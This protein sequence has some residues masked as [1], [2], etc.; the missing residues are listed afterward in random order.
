MSWDL[1]V[2][3]PEHAE[4]PSDWLESLVEEAADVAAAREHVRIV[5]ER[6]PE[7]EEFGPEESGA[8][9]LSAPEQ[10]RLPF[11]V[12]LDGRHAAI[13]VAYWDMG[14]QTEALASLVE[15]VVTALSAH[16]GWIAFD[17]QED[18]P[19][20]LDEL[21]GTFSSGHATGVGHVAEIIAEEEAEP[22]PSRFRR[23][24]G[25]H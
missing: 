14:D 10:S 11:Q 23:L 5:K 2:V 19:L 8:I 17:P 16:T 24:W 3:P 12:L 22:R 13:N 18:R 7:L 6:R 4:D 20:E 9:E 1:Y 21:R 25:R 15:D